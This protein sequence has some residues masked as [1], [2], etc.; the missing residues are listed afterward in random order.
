MLAAAG[1][2]AP[3]VSSAAVNNDSGVWHGA[4]AASIRPEESLLKDEPF[5]LFARSFKAATAARNEREQRGGP[6]I[7]R[8]QPTHGRSAGPAPSGASFSRDA[9]RRAAAHEK[10]VRG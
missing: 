8:S 9:L 10:A 1:T 7:S 3:A 2:L 5:G 6:P 4:M